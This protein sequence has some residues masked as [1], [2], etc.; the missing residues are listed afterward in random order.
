MF[1]QL[2]TLLLRLDSELQS[3]LIKWCG[4]GIILCVIYVM[5]IAP[6][7]AWR[8][9]AI[10]QLHQQQLRFDKQ[11]KIVNSLYEIEK[12]KRLVSN[13]MKN[14]PNQLLKETTDAAA[15]GT[16]MGLLYSPINKYNLQIK[17]RRFNA[18]D[19]IA[20]LGAPIS[21]DLTL[22]GKLND[23]YEFLDRV[24]KSRLL[25]T[26][27]DVKVRN[28]SDAYELKVKLTTYRQLPPATLN[29]IS[30]KGE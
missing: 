22:T 19:P 8:E 23:I 14:Y 7:F 2:K 26:V 16:F 11:Q 21:I 4:L 24:Q 28:Y 3:P 12:N 18:G 13:I 9:E 29:K 5:L 10:S 6:Y 15:Q 17:G 20:F 30:N 1:S 25:I 27:D